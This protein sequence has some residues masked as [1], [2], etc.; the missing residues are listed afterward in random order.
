MIGIELRYEKI[1]LIRNALSEWVGG[2][3]WEYWFTGTFKPSQA[4]KDTINTK[5]AFKTFLQKLSDENDIKQI[6]YFM[7]V[8]RF[9]S[10]YDTHV[11]ALLSG[12]G[13]L[14]YKT[15]GQTW[16]SLYGRETVE[17][18]ERDKGAN[19]YLTKYVT[20]ELCDWDLKISRNKN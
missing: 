20:K 1:I 16:R 14:P 15:I 13:Y 7:A 19:Y 10:G 17:G 4:R 3:E 6:N 2:Y 12:I 5:I 9:K 18:Y 11:H 8:E